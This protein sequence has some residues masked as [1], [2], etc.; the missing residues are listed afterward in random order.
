MNKRETNARPPPTRVPHISSH[1]FNY[2]F[3]KNKRRDAYSNF[4]L[5]EDA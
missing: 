5:K 2:R 3:S 4:G 1:N